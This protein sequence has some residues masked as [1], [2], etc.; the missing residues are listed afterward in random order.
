MNVFTEWKNIEL[1]KEIQS[2][3]L[4]IPY[5]ESVEYLFPE[6]KNLWNYEKNHPLIPSHFRI[7]SNMKVWIKCKSGHSYERQIN[8]MFRIRNDAK[9]DNEKK[10]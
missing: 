2:S 4:S 7:G 3:L 8:H 5:D 9:Y 10:L 6:S 1:Y